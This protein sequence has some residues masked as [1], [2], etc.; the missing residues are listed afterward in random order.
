MA[1]VG[2]LVDDLRSEALLDGGHR[3]SFWLRRGR[4]GQRQP[5]PA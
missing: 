4:D 1:L 3:T 5:R 2:A